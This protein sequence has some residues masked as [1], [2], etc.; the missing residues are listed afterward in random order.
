MKKRNWKYINYVWHNVKHPIR[1]LSGWARRKDGEGRYASLI[2]WAG[3]KQ[4]RAE[5]E[6]ARKR[7]K[8]VKWMYKEELERLRAKP[9]SSIGAADF[10][11]WMLNGRPGNI[12]N[13]TKAA[14]ARGVH[15][16]LVVTSTTTGGHASTSFHFPWNNSDN[17]GH[18]VD[19]AADTDTMIEWQHDELNRGEDLLELFGPENGACAKNGAR[20][21]I[22][23]TLASAHDNHDH[24]AVRG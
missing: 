18:A 2:K 3:V 4:K 23:G 16:G 24:R 22:S 17:Q 10:Q 21:T 12:S 14:I 1:Q 5:T 15:R 9:L 7:W 20:I 13:G 6:R 11:P 19:M 8:K